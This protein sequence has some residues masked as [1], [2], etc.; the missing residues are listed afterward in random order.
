MGGGA[1]GQPA[2]RSEMGLGQTG[3]YTGQSGPL[4]TECCPGVCGGGRH[5]ACLSLPPPSIKTASHSA[6]ALSVICQF[7]P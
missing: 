5:S 3:S 6:G 7:M 4:Y 1:G 2:V